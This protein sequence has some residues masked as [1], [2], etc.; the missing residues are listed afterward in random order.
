ELLL[1]A[2]WRRAGAY[3]LR[4]RLDDAGGAAR[5]AL[6]LAES[7]KN[8]AAEA[9]LYRILGRVDTI[10]GRLDAARERFERALTLH[11]AAGDG[12]GEGHVLQDLGGLAHVEGR[13]EQAAE[14]YAHALAVLRE[15][16]ARQLEAIALGHLGLTELETGD[17][18][19]AHRHLSASLEILDEMGSV[20]MA[21][22]TR[23]YLAAIRMEQHEYDRARE[24]LNMVL[25]TVPLGPKRANTQLS[26]AA[27]ANTALLEHL[28]GR[29]EDARSYYDRFLALAREV[30]ADREEG[31]LLSYRAALEAGVGH[32]GR[33]TTMFDRARELL[34]RG[35]NPLLLTLLEVLEG[36]RHAAEARRS[37]QAGD[38][39]GVARGLAAAE[40]AVQRAREVPQGKERAPYA[41]SQDVRF[42][43]RIVTNDLDAAR[44]SLGLEPPM[45]PVLEVGPDVTWIRPPGGERIP[46][47]RRH[48]A[49]RVIAGLVRA[50]LD[51]PGTAQSIDQVLE[52]GWPSETI[53][54][55][56]AMN[57][58]Y[59]TITRLR[60]LGLGDV[61]L[62]NEDGYLLDPTTAV[63]RVDEP[64]PR[65]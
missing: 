64:M 1:E 63:H 10:K 23:V 15:V 12:Y 29:P 44:A 4:G 26:A 46:L 51:S 18:H 36:S 50:R 45:E 11:R 56:A 61:L 40:K 58:V 48:V 5:E 62:T 27:L 2:L 6:G 31:I 17:P 39:A 59:V 3:R 38:S 24:Q 65:G 37:G 41:R 55:E 54:W 22:I 14:C 53:L 49:R 9:D 8:V 20:R 33:A 47:G 32:L 13:Y 35:D 57:R 43:V 16:G 21:A 52:F 28:S 34:A 30:G 42:A 25:A 19:L 7:L 60:N